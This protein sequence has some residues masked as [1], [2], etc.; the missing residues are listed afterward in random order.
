MNKRLYR[1][2][3]WWIL[4]LFMMGSQVQQQPDQI[5][6]QTVQKLGVKVDF[7]VYHYGSRA[8]E[9]MPT[10]RMDQFVQQLAK[11]L[12]CSSIKKQQDA[13]GIHYQAENKEA[14]FTTK[15]HVLNDRPNHAWAKPYVS[16]QRI[17]SGEEKAQSNSIY[18]Q[19]KRLL[20]THRFPPNIQFTI[21]G[22]R[23]DIQGSEKQLVTQALQLLQAKEIEGIHTD[24]FIS[25]SANSSILPLQG[26][27]TR[28][29]LMNVQA[30][31]KMDRKNHKQLFT[32]GSPIIT[33]EY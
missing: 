11:D 2:L 1:W 27:P 3:G 17:G 12:E 31:A 6:F 28:N 9:W 7:V 5:L 10:N 19:W 32:I 13:L 23:S 33:I 22:S 16:I 18:Q 15:L 21:R 29:G 4:S 30:A 20:I 24:Q 25:S 8:S 26:I 14:H